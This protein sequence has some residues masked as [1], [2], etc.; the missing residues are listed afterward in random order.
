MSARASEG[1]Y[2]VLRCVCVFDFKGLSAALCSKFRRRAAAVVHHSSWHPEI[3][4]TD[5][6]NN[7]FKSA[8]RYIHFRRT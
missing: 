1:S 3:T 4:P 5:G 8:G 2:I 7:P 6:E